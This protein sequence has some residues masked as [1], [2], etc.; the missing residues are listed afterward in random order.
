MARDNSFSNTRKTRTPWWRSAERGQGLVEYA[1]GLVLVGMTA[2]VSL[3]LVGPSI[4]EALCD[5]VETV[6]PALVSE[7]TTTEGT[8]TSILFAKY[9][10]GKGELDVQAKASDSC[11]YD[12]EIKV[13]GVHMGTMVRMGDSYVFKYNEN[14]TT[15]PSSVQ[16][17]HPDC[18]GFTSLLSPSD[19]RATSS[20]NKSLHLEAFLILTPRFRPGLI[21]IA[22]PRVPFFDYSS[23][24]RTNAMM[25]SMSP[26]VR[27]S[28]PP[29]GGMV[30]PVVLA[31]SSAVLPTST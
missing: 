14:P 16:V 20:R 21:P 23:I 3:A 12:L 28:N 29:F 11:P 17:G 8:G 2:S 30:T 25:D 27:N 31:G 5:V 15:P 7:C 13:D 22:L 6:N 24:E 18:G 19:S 1:L 4:S 9:N 10:A 26:S